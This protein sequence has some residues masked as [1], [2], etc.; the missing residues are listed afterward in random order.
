[1]RPVK[2]RFGHRVPEIGKALAALSA[3]WDE[4]IVPCGG[5]A[6]NRLG[7]TR[8]NPV[9]RVFLTSGPSRRLYFGSSTVELRHAPRWQLTAPHRKAGD[10]VRA[11]SWIGPRHIED[12]LETVL[13]NLSCQELDELSDACATMPTWMAQPLSERL[14]H[15]HCAYLP[16]HPQ[17]KK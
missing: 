2:T 7:L 10:V 17:R 12:S 6:A 8:Q 1:M 4:T 3:L 16:P 9:R 5:S 13:P 14:T 11:L 15:I